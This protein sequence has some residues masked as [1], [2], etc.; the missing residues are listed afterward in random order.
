MFSM[1]K[2][3]QHFSDVSIGIFQ[4][5]QEKFYEDPTDMASFIYG[6][7][8]ELRALGVL[9]IQ[10]TLEEIDQQIRRS[11][12]R[13][14]SWVI[15]KS[16][17][18]KLLTSLGAV[19]FTKTL[20]TNKESGEMA[21][22]LDRILGL[23]PHAR[24]TEDAEARLLTEAV[25][26]SYRR[27]GEASTISSDS[28]SKEAVKDRL[29]SLEIPD[30]WEKPEAKRVVDYLYV[31]ADEDHVSLQFRD[32]KGDLEQNAVGRKNNSLISK[33]VYVHEGIEPDAPKSKR[34]HLKNPRYF[35][36]VCGEK[37]NHAFWDRIYRY[38]CDTYEVDQ[39]KRIYL[40][41]DGGGWIK[42]GMK[43]IHGLIFVMDEF[44]LSKYLI[45]LT[46]HMK[47]STEDAR[48]ELYGAIRHGT[49]EEFNAIVDRLRDCLPDESGAA[50]IEE[51]RTYFLNNWMPARRRLLHQNG[52][53]GCSAEGHVSHLLSSRMSSRPMGWSRTGAKKMAQLRA[54]YQNGGDMLEL[55]R[56]QSERLP[57]AAGGEDEVIYSASEMLA[58]ER[59]NQKNYGKYIEKIQ[60]SIP[61]GSRK[62]IHLEKIV[63][64]L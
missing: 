30:E 55:V 46:S 10:E 40:S 2:S 17:H 9:M 13:K 35:V 59:K 21:C 57:M 45:R 61:Q 60:A 39:I 49:K 1:D 41:A 56:K 47:D 54:Y 24:L 50:R 19:D 25:Q 22:L 3:I 28:V 4:K 63:W 34:H 42:S 14:K 11:G 23:S 6:I 16:C 33:M 7:S 31:E 26:T 51:A 53:I 36:D 5:L 15:E 18:K 38:I 58:E 8:D 43:R 52:V 48:K 64:D 29:H 62:Y 27:G 37:E 12:K 44:H 20:F 32:T